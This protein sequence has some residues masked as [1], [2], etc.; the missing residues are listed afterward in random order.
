MACTTFS[1]DNRDFVSASTDNTMIYLWDLKQVEYYEDSKGIGGPKSWNQ[2]VTKY[3]L[4]LKRANCNCTLTYF[5][6]AI[7]TQAR[8]SSNIISKSME[9]ISPWTARTWSGFRYIV[10][11]I[12]IGEWESTHRGAA[13]WTNTFLV[14]QGLVSTQR[15]FL[16]AESD[17]PRVVGKTCYSRLCRLHDC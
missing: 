14:V 7:R 8:S 9:I 16:I 6:S 1:P 13:Q 17:G 15:R 12:A 10:G 4:S 5:S 11:I 3:H 2:P